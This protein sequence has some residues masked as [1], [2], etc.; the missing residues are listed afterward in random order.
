MQEVSS[1]QMQPSRSF[2]PGYD[3]KH[4][5]GNAQPVF[6]SVIRGKLEFLRMVRGPFFSAYR[7]LQ[8]RFNDLYP[9]LAV[10]LLATVLIEVLN[11]A[12]WCWNVT[13][14]LS[15]HRDF[16][17]TTLDLFTCEHVLGKKTVAYRAAEPE[18]RYPVK[19]VARNST[20]DLAVLSIDVQ[21]SAALDAQMGH[22]ARL[23]R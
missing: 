8:K 2:A 22:G 15:R 19:I 10:A 21:A 6:A 5:L 14:P 11:S 16:S 3:K 12:L 17:S 4:R 7:S 1:E 18:K 20:I 23:Q 13:K 9:E